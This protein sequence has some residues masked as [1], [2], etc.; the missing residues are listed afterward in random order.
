MKEYRF[1]TSM[2]DGYKT[3][4]EALE[5]NLYP[6]KDKIVALTNENYP[7]FWVSTSHFLHD[8]SKMNVNLEI[9]GMLYKD[10][11]LSINMERGDFSLGV[12]S[13]ENI[14]CETTQEWVLVTVE[15][16][17]KFVQAVKDN[18][19]FKWVEAK[20]YLPSDW[21]C[22]FLVYRGDVD[23]ELESIFFELKDIFHTKLI[24]FALESRDVDDN[25]HSNWEWLNS[26]CVVCKD[27]NEEKMKEYYIK[28]F[29]WIKEY[30]LEDV[31]DYNTN[32]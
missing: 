32:C 30:L 7:N 24:E 23:E 4:V 14:W 3:F 12:E 10:V 29:P 26:T 6:Y 31:Y 9:D 13:D 2:V 25:T 1:T 11:V 28:R 18:F 5:D 15:L 21:D 27:Y 16:Y 19:V 22:Y 8:F 20:W 17:D